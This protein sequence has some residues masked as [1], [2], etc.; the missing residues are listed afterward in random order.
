M[1]VRDLKPKDPV[2]IEL[3]EIPDNKIVCLSNYFIIGL[4]SRISQYVL[5]SNGVIKVPIS[6]QK[7]FID[8]ILTRLLKQFQILLI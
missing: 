7:K 6:K 1:Y 4:K 2:C 3:K 8:K 5:A